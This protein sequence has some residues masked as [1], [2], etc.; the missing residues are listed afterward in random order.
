MG[1]FKKKKKQRSV[2]ATIRTF[3]KFQLKAMSESNSEEAT[4]SSN[5]LLEGKDDD[6]T[7]EL[8]STKPKIS[9]EERL[10]LAAKLDSELDQFIAGLEKRKYADG[11]PED[12]WEEE[13]RKH[14]F[15][16][17]EAP[18]PGDDIHPLF[19]GMQKLKYDPEENTTEELALNYKEDGNW[20]M[21]Y[22][23]FRMA[24]IA[25][26]EGLKFKAKNDELNAVLYNNRSAANYMLKN[27]R[28]ALMDAKKALELKNDYLKCKNRAALCCSYLER[29]DECKNYCYEL[30]EDDPMNEEI[31]NL[32]IEITTKEV[33]LL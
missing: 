22:K 5:E 29:F 15:F 27:Y 18:K 12:K 17:K 14:P 4:V 28:S 3:I 20:Y 8:V 9:D 21:K 6:K 30:L 23:K 32:I 19:E 2:R 7:E 24:I 25:Y 13:I 10:E 33:Y 11:W 1:H 16:M 26:T 31:S